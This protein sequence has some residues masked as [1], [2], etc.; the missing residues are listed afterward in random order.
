MPFGKKV[1]PFSTTTPSSANTE[2]PSWKKRFKSNFGS[3]K[4][5]PV[6]QHVV[7]ASLTEKPPGLWK[8]GKA[9]E[10]YTVKEL[11]EIAAKAEINLKGL[12]RKADIIKK[13]KA[14]R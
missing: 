4:T 2:K 12:T 8:G 14:T 7:D 3:D 13:I 9:L 5:V 11:R 6:P 1:A 10:Q